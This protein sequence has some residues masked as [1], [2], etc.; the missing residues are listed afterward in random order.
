VTNL[1]NLLVDRF[2]VAFEAVAGERVDP[3]VRRSQHADFQAD[4]ALP[5]A[6]KLGR[7]PREIATDVLARVDLSGLVESATISGPGFINVTIEAAALAGLL[8]EMQADDRLG[9]PVAA[10]PETVVVDYSAPNGAKEMHVGHLRSTVIGDAVARLLTWLDHDV[11]RANHVGDWGTPFGMLIEHLLD[12]GE[13]E[14][15]HELSVGD[16]NGIYRAARVKFDSDPGF[17]DRSRGRV[18]AL[19]SGDR[20]TL[21][22]WKLLVAES[23]RHFLAVYDTLDVML[24]SDDFFGESFYNPMLAPVVDE[25]DRLGLL[26]ESDGAKV[27]LPA[28]F[29]GRDGEPMPLIVR[30][31]DGG[32]G[33]GA[34]D[35]ATIRYRTQDLKA[36]R[37]LYVVGS[38]QHQH[39]EMV[40]QT[41][42]EAGWL[43][44]PARATHIGFGQ[45]LG[46]DGKKFASRAGD[47]VKLADLLDEAI[48]RA[49]AIITEKNPDL[50]EATRAAV[51][52]AVGIGAIKYADLS[53]DWIKDYVFAWDRMLATTGDTAAYLQY[54]YARIQSIF[55]KGGVT[56]ERSGAA[57]RVVES[58]E[59]ALALELLGFPAII[60]EVAE[61]LQFHKLTGYLQGLAGAYTTFYDQC[62]VLKADDET[63][64]SRLVL[65]ALTGR[66]ITQGL[67][68]LGIMTPDRM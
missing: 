14:A 21:R 6:R 59:H 57:I 68:L 47:T 10:S 24:T 26:H 61:T 18:V 20:T 34:T 40:Y 52:H 60:D 25:L 46:A 55:R 30:K 12:L 38:P 29:T 8:T 35:L 42:R 54:T 63:R 1:E 44:P 48:S 32:Y 33:Y 9:V 2:A 43:A 5:L 45:V 66:V 41:A 31:R 16:L 28:G 62:P 11:Q 36:T 15:A 51:A 64:A 58:A 17:A 13:T 4:G 7:A 27:V 19:Q 65:C 49:S 56:S 23:E 50:D 53:S 67:A 37:L 3:V 39:L 22:L